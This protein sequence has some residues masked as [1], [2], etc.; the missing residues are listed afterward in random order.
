[1]AIT[2]FDYQRRDLDLLKAH[3]YRGLLNL[4]TGAGKTVEGVL[5]HVESGA[6][7]TLVI[8]PDQ[9]HGSAWIPTF[10]KAGIEARPMGN[11]NK[12]TKAA[13]TDFQLGYPGVYLVTPQWF[14]REDISEWTGDL[15]LVD[16]SHGV[17]GPGSKGNRKLAG[18]SPKEAREALVTRFDGRMSLSGTAL[19]NRFEYA[20]SQGR[21]LWPELYERGQVAYDNFWSWQMDRMD[22]TEIYTNQ[23][24][25]FGNVKKVKKFLTEKVPGKWLG[26]APLVITHFKRRQCCEFHPN[27]FLPMD[28]PTVIHETIPMTPAQKRAIREM[29]DHL[30]T[31]LGD[32]PLVAEIPLTK[33]QRI[34]QM[35]LGVPKVVYDAEKD[36]DTVE[37]DPECESP[38][39]DWVLEFL[40]ESDEPVVIYTD[41]QRFA[42][43]TTHRL[44]KAGIPAF[45]Y[46]GATRK[47][48]DEDAKQFGGKYRVIVAVLAAIA[49]GY[50][51]L[52]KVAKTEVWLN[53]S[54]DGT[55]NTQAEGRLD[56]I[57]QNGQV[58]RIY[59]HDDL[60]ISEGRFSEAVERRLALNRSLQK[61]PA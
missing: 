39:L 22:Y 13:Y 52:Q 5:S 42:A 3:N 46:S 19:R 44:N 53:T 1:M 43:V 41:S 12:T 57:G 36:A 25:R 35:T 16:E 4:E 15:L 11:R 23:R 24:D 50:D 34:R 30:M 61:V 7:V 18:F 17:M 29:E 45:E 49:E 38:Y 10:A 20:W 40:D 59:L 60:G 9:T 21:T 31:W 56:R 47:T 8:A 2:P 6:D 32:N 26:E 51:G 55:I 58:L 33:N 48:R 54:L 37:F 28:E 14:T 27:G